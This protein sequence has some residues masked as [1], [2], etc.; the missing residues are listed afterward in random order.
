[1][2]TQTS[3]VFNEVVSELDVEFDLAEGATGV[4]G[5]SSLDDNP[6]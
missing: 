2:H 3:G 5:V 1:M 4:T 6:V